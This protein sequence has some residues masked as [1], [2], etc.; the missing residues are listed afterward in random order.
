MQ[1]D[2]LP[3]LLSWSRNARLFPCEEERGG[4]LPI[5]EVIDACLNGIGYAGWVSMEVFSRTLLED[6]PLVPSEHAVRA[7][8]SWQ[9]V[10]GTL[11]WKSDET[12]ASV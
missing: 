12:Q 9:R 8:R 3:K 4:Y 7:S 2:K 10:L 11:G 1:D 5:N 6:D